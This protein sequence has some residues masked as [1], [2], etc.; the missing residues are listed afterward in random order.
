MSED[1]V[2]SIRAAERFGLIPDREFA[3]YQKALV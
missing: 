1:N 3:I 2:L